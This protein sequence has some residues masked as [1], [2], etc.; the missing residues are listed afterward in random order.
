MSYNVIIDVQSDCCCCVLY[1]CACN[2]G[3]C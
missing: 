1:I 2:C 3:I